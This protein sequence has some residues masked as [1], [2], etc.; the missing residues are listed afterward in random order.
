MRTGTELLVITNMASKAAKRASTPLVALVRSSIWRLNL[1]RTPS[2]SI[3]EYAEDSK[4]LLI[5]SSSV[6]LYSEKSV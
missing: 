6:A 3:S 5:S 4:P 1:Q 2:I